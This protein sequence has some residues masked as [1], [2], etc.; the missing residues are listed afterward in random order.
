MSIIAFSIVNVY[1]PSRIEV[2]LEIQD[3]WTVSAFNVD[4]VFCGI[5]FTKSN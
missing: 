5:D 2:L 1:S 3:K 4:C